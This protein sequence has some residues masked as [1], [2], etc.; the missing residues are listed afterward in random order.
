M[1]KLGNGWILKKDFSERNVV[2]Y[3][4]ICEKPIYEDSEY[5]RRFGVLYCYHCAKKLE[6]IK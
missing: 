2:G 3:C 4:E 6:K 5:T 1:E